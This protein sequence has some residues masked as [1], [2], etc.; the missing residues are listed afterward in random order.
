MYLEVISEFDDEKVGEILK[1]L[2]EHLDI[3]PV[4]ATFK[5]VN[6]EVEITEEKIGRSIDQEDLKTKIYNSD[7]EEPIEISVIEQNPKIIAEDFKN[8]TGSIGEF[9]TNYSSSIQARKDNIKHSAEILNGTVIMPGEQFSF[10]DTIGKISTDTGFF[11]AT[12]IE[13]GEFVSGVGGGICQ[14]ST[15]LYM[16][17]SK[18]DL[19][20]D[21]RHNHSRPINYVP[22][23]LDAAVAR[24][25]DLKFTNPFEFP[26][27]IIAKADDNDIVFEIIGNREI[28]DYDVDIVVEQTDSL[29]SNRIEKKDSSMPVGT[30]EVTQGGYSGSVYQS[31][32]VKTKNGQELSRDN[33]FRSRYPARDTIISIGTGENADD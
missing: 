18:A 26:I 8:I 29:E 1:E 33:Y 15:T 9:S 17:A 25:L 12:V 27:Y 24:G 4:D 7:P 19:Q 10:N 30:S 22:R 3:E 23:G 20:I 11:E 6:G 2:A 31:F 16:A 28:K 32:K 5:I 13:D 14:T 21:E